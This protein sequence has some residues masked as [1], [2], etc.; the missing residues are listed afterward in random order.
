MTLSS[1]NLRIWDVEN[2]SNQKIPINTTESYIYPI[3]A[4]Y[5]NDNSEILIVT[6]ENVTIYRC[7]ESVFDWLHKVDNYYELTEDDTNRLGID[8]ISL[9]K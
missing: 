7:Y 9:E 2:E 1:E 4:E 6:E 3:H 8:Y 5:S